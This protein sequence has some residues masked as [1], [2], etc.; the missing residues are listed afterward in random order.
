M[1]RGLYHVLGGKFS[2]LDGVEIEDLNVE[3]LYE[4]LDQG[5]V[6]EVILATSPDVDG[7]ATASY[8]ASLLAERFPQLSLSRIATGLPVGSDLS[9]ADSATMASALSSRRTFET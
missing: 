3:S 8:L 2:P 7:E 1:F 4:R 9:Y 6:R 5:K